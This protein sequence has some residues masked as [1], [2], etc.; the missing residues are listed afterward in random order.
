MFSLRIHV[1]LYLIYMLYF[2]ALSLFWDPTMTN[3]WF[4][5]HMHETDHNFCQLYHKVKVL[6]D[7]CQPFR[8]L[9]FKI[10]IIILLYE[11]NQMISFWIYYVNQCSPF[12]FL[13]VIIILVPSVCQNIIRWN[14]IGVFFLL[15]CIQP[16]LY[17]CDN[18]S[19]SIQT[20]NICWYD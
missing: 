9:I 4:T 5:S 2:F 16:V 17:I 12:C 15:G 6:A 3:I 8:L 11:I 13:H 1:I 20:C 14:W 7:I 19:S 18:F 10:L